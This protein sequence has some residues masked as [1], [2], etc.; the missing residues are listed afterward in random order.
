MTMKIIEVKKPG[1]GLTK[2]INKDFSG[3]KKVPIGPTIAA[4]DPSKK[5]RNHA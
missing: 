3:K 2:A 4:R 5:K 1:K